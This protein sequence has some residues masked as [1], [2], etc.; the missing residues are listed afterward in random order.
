MAKASEVPSDA[1]VPL[2]A[3]V[4]PTFEV[5][6]PAPAAEWFARESLPGSDPPRAR[7]ARLSRWLL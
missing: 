6:R 3:E 7:L 2:P 4:V 1:P 5:D